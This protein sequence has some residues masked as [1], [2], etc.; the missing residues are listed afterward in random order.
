M[1]KIKTQTLLTCGAS[2]NS[3]QSM[4]HEAYPQIVTP[5]QG[6]EQFFREVYGGVD[7]QIRSSLIERIGENLPEHVRQIEEYGI[8][9]ISGLFD[10]DQIAQMHTSLNYLSRLVI[11]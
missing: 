6:A 4:T 8:T 1:S 9:K 5:E 3:I 7:Q 11:L 10:A 2:H